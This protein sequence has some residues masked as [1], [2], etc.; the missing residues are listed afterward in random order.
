MCEVRDVLKTMDLNELLKIKSVE[1]LFTVTI[2]MQKQ[3]WQLTQQVQ[4]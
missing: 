1:S 2:L 3:Y 4:T